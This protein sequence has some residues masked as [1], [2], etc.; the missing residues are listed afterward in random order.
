MTPVGPV[1]EM[2]GID[3]GNTLPL[4]KGRGVGV[5]EKDRI[6]FVA[7]HFRIRIPGTVVTGAGLCVGQEELQAP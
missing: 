7:S 6:N 2:T 5:P 1:P 4:L 3:P